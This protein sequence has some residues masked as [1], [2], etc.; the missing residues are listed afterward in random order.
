MV[1]VSCLSSCHISCQNKQFSSSHGLWWVILRRLRDLV[2]GLD[3]IVG[4]GCGWVILLGLGLSLARYIQKS[5]IGIFFFPIS[6]EMIED[7]EIET[8]LMYNF[9]LKKEIVSWAIWNKWWKNTVLELVCQ[10][11]GFSK[12]KMKI[13]LQ[14]KIGFLSDPWC[15]RISWGRFKDQ[16]PAHSVSL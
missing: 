4:P 8:M 15:C 10:E 5:R 16:E 9:K 2:R 3:S 11:T 14:C 13:I 1:I 6:L 12:S 7:H